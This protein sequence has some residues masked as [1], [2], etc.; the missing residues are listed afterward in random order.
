MS[1]N[2]SSNSTNSTV[3]TSLALFA[4]TVVAALYIRNH[5][6]ISCC[7]S[8]GGG[9]SQSQSQQ[10]CDTSS[11]SACCDGDKY[12][13]AD[14]QL[15]FA[16]AQKKK[17]ARVLDIDSAYDPS[18]LRGKVALVTGGNRGVFLGCSAS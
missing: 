11:S 2:S 17:N 4:A 3:G 9:G 10:C 16:T 12:S 14:Q 5:C 18:S 1:S 6:S 15:R 8:T 7:G 13:I